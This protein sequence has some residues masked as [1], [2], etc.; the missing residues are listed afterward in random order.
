VEKIPAKPR[1]PAHTGK[2]PFSVSIP[3]SKEVSI[4]EDRN[5]PD[6]VKIYS[7]GSAQEGKVGAAAVLIFPDKPNHVLHFH[8]GSES[9]H[10]VPEAELVGILL[11]LHLIKSER[12]K[13]TSFAI[14]SDNQ[15]GLEAFQTSLKNPAHN[16]AREILWQGNM[17]RKNSRGKKFNLT[18]RWTAGHVGIPGNELADA[19]AKRAA[20]SLSSD[21]SILPKF[22]RCSL[23]LNPTALQRRRNA[24]IKQRWKIKWK[25][26]KREQSLAKIDNNSS[27]V[28]FLRAISKTNILCRLASLIT[29]LYIGHVPLNDYLK[30]FKKADSARCPACRAAPETVRHFLLECPI[31][32]HERWILT[33]RLSKRDKEL[34]LENIL[35]DEEA[36]LSLSNY[37]NASHRFARHT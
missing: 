34:T 17:L 32:A 29:Q 2:L 16:I 23:T 26:S 11:A 14:G 25:N 24:E 30:R 12:N 22:L 8:L 18:L 20:G 13:N 31:Y 33:R 28:H 4:A 35:G 27:L 15:A 6:T 9:E 21:K 36:F 10:T 3:T 1:N 5:A 19:E 37:I 7:D